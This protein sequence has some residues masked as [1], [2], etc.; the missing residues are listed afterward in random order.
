MATSGHNYHIAGNAEQYVSEATDAIRV[1]LE[2]ALLARGKASLL[3]SGGSSPKPVY[4]AL[5]Q[6]ALD[7]KNIIVS[8]VDERWVPE[9]ADGSNASFIKETL[10]QNKAAEATF[11]PLVNDSPTAKDGVPDM[12][13]SFS[14]NFPDP[15]DICIM[16]MGT[17]GHTASWFPGSKTLDQA[18]EIERAESLVWQDASGQD[19][20]GGFDDRITVSLP[21]VMRA[22]DVFLLIPGPAKKAVWEDSAEKD[23][24]EAPVTTLRAAEARLHVYTHEGA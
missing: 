1:R 13:E 2:D 18:L 7:W 6:E 23:I 9:G 10:L 15:V 24:H 22:R 12:A 4:Q 21:I 17:D 3:V 20:G 11:F 19:G 5:S 8:L 16:G 14:Q